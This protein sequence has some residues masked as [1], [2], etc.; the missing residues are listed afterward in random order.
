[1]MGAS[2]IVAAM[3]IAHPGVDER[4]EGIS[5]QIAADPDDAELYLRRGEL[6]TEDGHFHAARHDFRRA[7]RLDPSGVRV[8]LFRG[9]MWL[10]AGDPRRAARELGRFLVAEPHHARAR[11]QRARALAQ[12]GRKQAAV[13][14]VTRALQDAERVDAEPYLFRGR[15]LHEIGRTDEAL[16]SVD[17]GI[18]ALGPV[19]VLVEFAIEVELDRGHTEAALDRVASL[20]QRARHSPHWLG[21]YGDILHAAGRDAEAIVF[22]VAAQVVLGNLPPARRNSPAMAAIGADLEDRMRRLGADP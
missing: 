5:R 17:A 21:R 6:H 12:L 16:A 22:Y 3:L 1:M 8:H 9:A 18:E 7:E 11:L 13:A 15:L 2:I 4:V 20:P 14:E 19:V 10:E